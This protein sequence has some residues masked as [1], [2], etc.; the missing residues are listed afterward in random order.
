MLDAMS[1]TLVELPDALN[2]ALD[3]AAGGMAST[4]LVAV[5]S[6]ALTCTPLGTLMPCAESVD[7]GLESRLDRSALSVHDFA[8]SC[9]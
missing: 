6:I 3:V 7:A 8:T 5:D 1:P 4:A 9:A 2:V